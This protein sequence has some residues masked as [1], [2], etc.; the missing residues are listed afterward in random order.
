M[1][2]ALLQFSFPQKPLKIFLWNFVGILLIDISFWKYN[3]Y[4]KM[5]RYTGHIIIGI[6]SSAN[7]CNSTCSDKT[8]AKN[9]NLNQKSD[10][11]TFCNTLL[12]LASRT[13]PSN[14]LAVVQRLSLFHGLIFL[15]SIT[16][17]LDPCPIL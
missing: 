2:D 12:A 4:K 11:L 17:W 16:R 3:K 10:I 9:L 13:T 6:V 1:R 5:R 7:Y 8:R 15:S 14:I